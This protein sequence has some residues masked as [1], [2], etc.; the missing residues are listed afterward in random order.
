MR[1]DPI[2]VMHQPDLEAA[3]LYALNRLQREL[4]PLVTYHTLAHTRDEVAPAADQFAVLEGVTGEGLLLLRTAVLYHDIGFVEQH[5]DHEAIS[6]RI[7]ATALP[8][9]AIYLIA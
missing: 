4:A 7:A 1:R 5:H 9:L 8:G 2:R 3:R 6:T